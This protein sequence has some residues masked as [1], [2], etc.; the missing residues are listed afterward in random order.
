MSGEITPYQDGYYV[1]H[2]G[3]SAS[4]HTP[5]KVLDLHNPVANLDQGWSSTILCLQHF[6]TQN[7]VLVSR[8]N[9]VEASAI[10]RL[11]SYQ[12]FNNVR[13]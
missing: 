4:S 8:S 9:N 2:T 7:Q 11:W 6:R 10:L 12:S 5:R 13:T 3:L 1:P